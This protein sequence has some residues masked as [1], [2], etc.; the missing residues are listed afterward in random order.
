MEDKMK[1]NIIFVGGIH[2][3]GKTTLC[4]QISKEHKI[5]H[6][7]SSD[8]I[9]KLVGSS[10]S[11]GKRTSNINSNQNILIESIESFCPKDNYFL[12][13]G[14]F[15]LID[16]NNNITRIPEQT[17]AELNLYSIIVLK[18]SIETISKNL[19]SRDSMHYPL[20]FIERFQNEELCYSKEISNLLKIDYKV[21]D[22]STNHMDLNAYVKKTYE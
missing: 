19:H 20:E 8:L 14:H 7:S 21:I 2:G 4:S 6:F 10:L 5:E 22:I 16:K 9:K 11:S 12:L 1:K 15:C 18:N 3:V 13:D 17:F